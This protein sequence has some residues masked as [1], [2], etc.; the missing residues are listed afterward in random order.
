MKGDIEQRRIVAYLDT[1]PG[2]AGVPQG[3]DIAAGVAVRYGGGIG[4][5][6]TVRAG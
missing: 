1:R 2:A 6:V 5:I 3:D 4:C